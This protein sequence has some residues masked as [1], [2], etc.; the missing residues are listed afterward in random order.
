MAGASVFELSN[1]LFDAIAIYIHKPR[2]LS[3]LCLASRII[4]HRTTP[5]L[6]SSWTYHGLEHSQ[7]SFRNFLQTTNW[8]PDLASYVKMLDVRERGNCP[9]LEDYVGFGKVYSE[10][11]EEQPEAMEEDNEENNEEYENSNISDDESDQDS[12]EILE[13]EPV[14]AAELDTSS[15][16]EEFNNA[17]VEIGMIF[18]RD[19]LYRL[20]QSDAE[21][22]GLKRDILVNHHKASNEWN[23]SVLISLLISKLPNLQTL[24]MVVTGVPWYDHVQKM[25]REESKKEHSNVLQN[26]ETLY[27]YSSLSLHT[28]TAHSYDSP[29]NF[30]SV[31]F[32]SVNHKSN[33]TTLVFDEADL[34]LSDGVKA[35]SIPKTLKTFRWTQE[36]TCYHIGT[37]DDPF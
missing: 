25:I 6:Y 23:E 37:F 4:Y 21:S 13:D 5:K 11:D 8:R 14:D 18:M 16:H 35:L 29:G 7:K 17:G 9:R 28:L 24:Y 15:P 3:N 20:L 2:D 30:E 12:V 26:L 34:I 1:E 22:L 33:I 36:I 10:E 32:K 27:Y 19:R 31:D